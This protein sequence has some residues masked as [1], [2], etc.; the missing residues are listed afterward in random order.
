[1][2]R[3]Q[4]THLASGGV[5]AGGRG[6]GP[7]VWHPLYLRCHCPGG[8]V[9]LSPCCMHFRAGLGFVYSLWGGWWHPPSLGLSPP[10]WREFLG[11]GYIS[12]TPPAAAWFSASGMAHWLQDKLAVTSAGVVSP[13]PNR[14]NSPSS[15]QEHPRLGGLGY[16]LACCRQS[17]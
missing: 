6:W 2:L 12:P 10:C 15:M 9:C 11:W 17:V 16:P 3:L 4:R 1:M 8:Y 14:R 13:A 7:G 5:S